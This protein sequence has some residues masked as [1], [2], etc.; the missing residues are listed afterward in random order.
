[1]RKTPSFNFW[2]L[3]VHMWVGMPV[4]VFT[5]ARTQT[6]NL[7]IRKKPPLCLLTSL[8]KYL[9]SEIAS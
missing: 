6:A 8:D 4:Y 3:V 9:E 1:M 5:H 7:I 2:P